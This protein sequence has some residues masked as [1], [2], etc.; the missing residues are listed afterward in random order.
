MTQAAHVPTPKSREAVA[1]LSAFGVP[2]L[3]IAK[4]LGISKP[5]LHKYYQDELDI[6][7]VKKNAK[8]AE[9][10]YMKATVDG[11]VTA[12]IFWL[13]TRAGWREADKE[14]MKK[15]VEEQINK[16]QIEVINA[17]NKGK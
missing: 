11:N 17:E 2:V 5:T 3:K 14:D 9:A 16:I 8:V 7:M 13:K 1:D 6:G 4:A 15:T 12:M 10:L